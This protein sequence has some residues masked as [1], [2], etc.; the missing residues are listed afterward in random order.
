MKTVLKN[1]EAVKQ[2]EDMKSCMKPI[3]VTWTAEKY[4]LVHFLLLVTFI[5]P[6]Y[7][8]RRTGFSKSP[9]SLTSC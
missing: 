8:S 5:P 7:L 4:G 3:F 2:L 6:T 1:I 9:V